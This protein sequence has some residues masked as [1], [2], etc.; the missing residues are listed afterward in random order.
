MVAAVKARAIT[1]AGLTFFSASLMSPDQNPI[2]VL[3]LAHRMSEVRHV[4]NV[5]VRRVLRGLD[6]SRWNLLALG[7]VQRAMKTAFAEV[8]HRTI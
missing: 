4:L 7:D 2:L 8:M 1:C 6:L 5:S 3:E